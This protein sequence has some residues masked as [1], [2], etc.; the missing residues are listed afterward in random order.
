MDNQRDSDLK[1]TIHEN[2]IFRLGCY[3][4]DSLLLLCL[5]ISMSNE[6]F[7]K[8]LSGTYWLRNSNARDIVT[9][10]NQTWIPPSTNLQCKR[11][12]STT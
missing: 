8:Y 3:Q 7:K 6:S 12:K 5:D 9:D 2:Y 11:R 1:D 4:G 10:I